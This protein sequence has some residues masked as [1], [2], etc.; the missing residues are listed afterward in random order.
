MLRSIN[1]CLCRYRDREPEG[2]HQDDKT[3]VEKDMG[4][5]KV[6]HR[7]GAEV[8]HDLIHQEEFLTDLI[9]DRKAVEEIYD[10]VKKVI[11]IRGV[12]RKGV[13]GLSYHHQT[14]ITVG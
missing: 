10:H 1:E 3:D 2:A 12:G 13:A 6:K 4:G 5:R 8:P 11:S 7:R 9:E 14:R